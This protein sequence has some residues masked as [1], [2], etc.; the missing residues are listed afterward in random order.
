MVPSP[1]APGSAEARAA[2]AA[3][4][5]QGRACSPLLPLTQVG[6]S[7]LAP[8]ARQPGR[9]AGGP[10]GGPAVGRQL[11]EPPWVGVRGGLALSPLTGTRGCFPDAWTET[12]TQVRRGSRHGSLG[13]G[14][15]LP[16]S[17]AVGPAHVWGTGG[18][19]AHGL[20]RGPT[21]GSLKLGG[22][23]GGTAARL[24]LLSQPGAGPEFHVQ[25]GE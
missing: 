6:T 22:P 7:N 11:A 2:W 14:A 12:W 25:G 15:S 3:G 21:A 17:A 24:R 19:G 18:G 16:G 10:Q 1:A 5:V 23:S 8:L 20:R 9:D 4:F 13:R